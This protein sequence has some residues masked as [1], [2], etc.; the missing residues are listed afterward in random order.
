MEHG[1]WF[2]A[3]LLATLYQSVPILL[4]AMG[5]VIS[6]R[7]GIANIALEGFLLTGAFVGVCVGQHNPALGLAAGTVAGGVLGVAHAFFVQRLRLNPII[8]GLA[9]NMLAAGST[10]FLALRLYPGGIQ[11]A[12]LLPKLPFLLLALALPLLLT[13]LLYRTRLGV[14]LRAIGESP[15]SARGLG[16]A[17]PPRRYLAVGLSGVF[18]GLGGVYLSLADVGTFTSD[19]SAGKGYIALAAV[20]FGRWKPIPTA[21]GAL[22]FGLLYAIQTQIQIGGHELHALGV[23]WSSPALLDCLPYLITVIALV[24]FAGRSVAPAALG[25]SESV[26]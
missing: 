9:L 15:K 10:R 22:L 19:M 8:S 18:A 4:A 6:E 24:S 16:I 11:A 17:I 1:G 23:T 20:I 12:T 2:A 25:Q 5:G 21:L 7:A 3:L 13:L 26:E 14:E